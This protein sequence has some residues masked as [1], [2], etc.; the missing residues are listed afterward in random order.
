MTNKCRIIT[1]KSIG[2]IA[3]F[4]ELHICTRAMVTFVFIFVSFL[5]MDKQYL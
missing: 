1:A 5:F 3:K 4:S 2:E